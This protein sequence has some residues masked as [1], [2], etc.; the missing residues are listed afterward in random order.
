MEI[1]QTRLPYRP[2]SDPGLSRLPGVLPLA[3]SEWL[4]RDE[5]FGGQMALRDRLIV[6]EG[7]VVKVD[8]PGSAVVAELTETVLS[9]LRLDAGYR[10]GGN[11]V[12]RPDGVE[13][14]LDADLATL[15]RLVQADLLIHEKRGEEHVLTGGLLLF[16]ASWSLRQKVGRPLASIHEPVGRYDAGIAR[17]VQRM[18]DFLRPEAPLWRANWLLY[19]DPDLFQPR[20]EAEP[21]PR[22][23]PGTGY[24]RSE[25][26]SFR[27]L[28][29]TG[30]VIFAI[31]TYVLP[32]AALD[33][34]PPPAG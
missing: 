28:P 27:K 31:H 4:V 10:V 7:D 1:L 34:D 2:W 29:D 25:R 14:V 13:V 23:A 3:P 33:D 24:L 17:R 12:M 16:P 6:A 30:A 22:P 20:T 11:S 32:I 5:A 18:F 26:Q 9:A 21:R 19:R 15:A 8:P